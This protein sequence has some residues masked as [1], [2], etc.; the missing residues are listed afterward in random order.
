MPLRPTEG[1]EVF[2][3]TFAIPSRMLAP[4][5]SPLL[6]SPLPSSLLLPVFLLPALVPPP[7]T[8]TT[9]GHQN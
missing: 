5:L 7:P 3:P 1:W 6:P 4:F 8:T 2:A 9:L